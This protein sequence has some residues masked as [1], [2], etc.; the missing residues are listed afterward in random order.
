MKKKKEAAGTNRRLEDVKKKRQTCSKIFYMSLDA[1][2]DFGVSV[3]NATEDFDWMIY[4]IERLQRLSDAQ[5]EFIENIK[6]SI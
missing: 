4:E 3:E 5:Q 6:K 1:R 2:E